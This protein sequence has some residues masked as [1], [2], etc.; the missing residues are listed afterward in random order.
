MKR[1]RSV[2]R[3]H[4]V[5]LDHDEA[6]LGLR[7]HPARDLERLRRVRAMRTGVDVFD[8]RVL[9][10]GIEVERLP[11]QTP[12]IGHAVAAP[13]HKYFRRLPTERCQ[14][15]SVAALDDGRRAT[16]QAVAVRTIV[17]VQLQHA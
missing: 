6:E 15:R 17:R 2:R 14:S 13:G 9:L 7:L 3:A 11:Y 16:A 1:L 4:A 5:H 12:D 10:R 8:D